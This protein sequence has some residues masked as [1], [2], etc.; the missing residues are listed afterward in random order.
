MRVSYSRDDET[1]EMR[2]RSLTVTTMT[3]GDPFDTEYGSLPADPSLTLEEAGLLARKLFGRHTTV[4]E[5]I[6][7]H[8]YAES[9]A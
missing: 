5:K 7:L 1:G 6:T 2:Q 3:N 9:P 4:E 8:R